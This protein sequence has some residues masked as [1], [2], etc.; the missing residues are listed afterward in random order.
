MG[1]VAELV[2][3]FCADS[4]DGTCS[5]GIHTGLIEAKLNEALE[6]QA[7]M[8]EITNAIN[9]LSQ[10]VKLK[11]LVGATG[12]LLFKALNETEQQQFGNLTQ[13]QTLV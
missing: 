6:G 8:E 2:F 12:E 9:E 4:E 11:I 5:Q 7:T 13:E 10:A 3:Q 1:S